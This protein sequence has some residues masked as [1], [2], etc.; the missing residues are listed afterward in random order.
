MNILIFE[1]AIKELSIKYNMQDI[2]V[3]NIFIK[4][5]EE[6]FNTHLHL[7]NK[8]NNAYLIKLDTNKK[9][10]LNNTTF[11]KISNIFEEKLKQTN[12]LIQ[13]NDAKKLVKNKTIVFFEIL[14]KTDDS[15]ICSF[16]NMIAILPFKNIPYIDFE[17]FLLGTKHYAVVHSYSYKNNKILLNCK[18]S[19][20][21]I[22][23]VNSVILNFNITRIN[24]YYGKR[25]KIYANEIPNK[26]IINNL[27]MVYPKEKI[28]FFKEKNH[29]K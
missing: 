11:K 9:I 2:D 12:K 6:I 25:V 13:I 28:F 17:N 22:K 5:S 16:N 14:K 8:N 1:Q 26:T 7:I 23:K 3:I 10:T 20:V 4:S 21:E 19:L 24:R 15:F 27:R 18:H 29:D